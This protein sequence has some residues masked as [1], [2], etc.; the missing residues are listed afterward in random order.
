MW[1]ETDH[2]RAINCLE[3]L[4][5]HIVLS[6]QRNH[7]VSSV[8]A[9]VACKSWG[10]ND[11]G[12]ISMLSVEDLSSCQDL[13]SSIRAQ[14]VPSQWPVTKY[15]QDGRGN[16]FKWSRSLRHLSTLR[17]PI[18][19]LW[20]I[21]WEQRYSSVI[22]CGNL[23]HLSYLGN[24]VLKAFQI[25][26]VQVT[27]QFTKYKLES[28]ALHSK[29]MLFMPTSPIFKQHSPTLHKWY[30][31]TWEWDSAQ[32]NWGISRYSPSWPLPFNISTSSLFFTRT[33]LPFA[34]LKPWCATQGNAVASFTLLFID[35]LAFS[36]SYQKLLPVLIT[37]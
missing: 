1:G 34:L 21:F 22:L 30:H 6:R 27:A 25:D 32:H 37:T 18:H 4:R 11:V 29:P 13:A 12:G 16:Y 2:L 15:G 9:Q 19:L 20:T 24:A 14:I 17:S 28:S 10:S 7:L 26:L 5:M 31:P 23:A 8:W 35:D 3:S 33:P 36:S